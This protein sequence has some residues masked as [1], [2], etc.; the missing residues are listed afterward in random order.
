MPRRQRSVVRRLLSKQALDSDLDFR[1]VLKPYEL[2]D[3]LNRPGSAMAGRQAVQR[4]RVDAK[5]FIN[6]SLGMLE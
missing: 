4:F 1:G 2:V 5:K 3:E 6:A